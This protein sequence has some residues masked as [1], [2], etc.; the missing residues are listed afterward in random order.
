MT[1]SSIG[2]L[3]YDRISYQKRSFLNSVINFG[4]KIGVTHHRW[5]S[6]LAIQC[7]HFWQFCF[8]KIFLEL[9]FSKCK[10]LFWS[11]WNILFLMKL[12]K[13]PKIESNLRWSKKMQNILYSI[14]QSKCL[15]SWGLNNFWLIFIKYSN[16]IYNLHKNLVNS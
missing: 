16:Y 10:S 6:F 1:L 9:N 12:V 13:M 11:R 15:S 3:S 2:L 8:S 7:M 4:R 14:F 5:R